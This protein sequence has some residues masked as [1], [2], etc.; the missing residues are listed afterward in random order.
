MYP[1]RQQIIAITKLPW[2]TYWNG[3]GRMVQYRSVQL[4]W[5]ILVG[6]R[7]TIIQQPFLVPRTPTVKLHYPGL[8]IKACNLLVERQII[9]AGVDTA[10]PD[11]GTSLTLPCLPA[12]FKKNIWVIEMVKNAGKLPPK[13][14]Q[15]FC[16][17]HK[18]RS[19]KRWTG[20]SDRSFPATRW[21]EGLGS[22][23]GYVYS[24]PAYCTRRRP[25]SLNESSRLEYV[26]HV[27]PND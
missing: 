15:L 9:G 21:P 22:N 17:A 6:M 3:K 8:N 19:W 27:F 5:S 4:S 25:I 11:P 16:P 12:L 13:G 24:A 18:D 10:A 14:Y 26:Q 7:T 1:P 2:K 23:C 20:S